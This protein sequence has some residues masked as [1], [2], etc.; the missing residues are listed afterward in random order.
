M[1]AGHLSQYAGSMTASATSMSQVALLH[2]IAQARPTG[3]DPRR[4]RQSLGP[5]SLVDRLE[6]GGVAP[7]VMNERRVTNR[8]PV[9]E[10]ANLNTDEA[11]DEI[12]QMMTSDEPDAAFYL[13][14]LVDVSLS[15]PFSTEHSG[16]PLRAWPPP[17]IPPTTLA[18][19]R[20]SR[21]RRHSWTPTRT[22][23]TFQRRRARGGLSGKTVEPEFRREKAVGDRGRTE[24]VDRSRGG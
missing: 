16:P 14:M 21:S 15:D 7:Q 10:G 23:G 20:P 3:H 17:S 1:H 12:W 13:R 18:P 24:V 9:A 11:L 8:V 22:P 5:N 19:K 2:R 4:S 6:R